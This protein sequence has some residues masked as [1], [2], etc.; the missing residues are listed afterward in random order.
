MS[1]DAEDRR[2]RRG[3]DQVG[4]WRHRDFLLLWSAQGV[5]A[6][7][8][9]IT[10]TALPMAAILVAGAG[11][12]DLGL[13]AVALTLPRALFAWLG[14][15]WVDRH[16]RRPVLIG[17]D[18]V[19]AVALLAIPAAAWLGWLSMP[20][21]YVIATITG[22]ATVLFEL[23]D[24]VFIADLV[25]REQLLDANGK[26]ESVDAVAEISGPALGGALVA[27]LTAPIAI[28]ADALTF[29]VSALLIAR[30]RKEEKIVA[31]QPETSFVADV[32]M[33]IHVVWRDPAVRALFIAAATMT[34]FG[35]FMASLYT[36]FA[37]RDL[38]LTPTE[39]GIAIGC[40]G[41]GAL[42]GAMAARRAAERFGPRRTLI[43]SLAL[44]AAMQALIALAPPVP[45]IAMAFLISTQVIGD[46]VLTVYLINET[47]LRQRLLPPESLGRAAGTFQVANGLLTPVGALVGAVLAEGIGMR[48]TLWLLAI[49]YALALVSLVLARRALPARA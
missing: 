13:L 33:G 29:V 44:G 32:R 5:S 18:V 19:R 3:G 30:I 38:G 17:A 15:G 42:A 1:T 35:S 41:I 9:R 27:W 10:R 12:I 26:R 47:T 37:L 23:A 34:L 25:G 36:L 14:G 4:L 43:G 22:V 39:L 40:G 8:S 45:W 49:G 11:A 31:S 20:L 16:R 48:P 24:H 7:G 46:G 6:V 21:L 28:A 2:V